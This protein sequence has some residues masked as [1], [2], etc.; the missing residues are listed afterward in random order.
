MENVKL[1][2]KWKTQIVNKEK[3]KQRRKQKGESENW[4]KK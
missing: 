2:R 3:R 4:M 1:E